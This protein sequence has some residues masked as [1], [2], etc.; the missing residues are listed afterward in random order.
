[1]EQENISIKNVLNYTI[2]IKERTTLKKEDRSIMFWE[3]MVINGVVRIRRIQDIM[4]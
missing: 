2:I 1:M 3:T 4:D